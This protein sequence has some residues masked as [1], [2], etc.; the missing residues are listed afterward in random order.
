[1]EVQDHRLAASRQS[2][3][4]LIV[5]DNPADAFL[6]EELL[7]LCTNLTCKISLVNTLAA[8]RQHL[9]DR[10]LP[11]LILLDLHLPDGV[12][13]SNFEALKA[14]EPSIAVVV[15]TGVED[16]DLA[17][18]LI[19]RGAQDYL[20]KGSFDHET[21]ARTIR[22]AIDRQKILSQLAL[23]RKLEQYLAYNDAL[24]GL[25]N[26]QFFRNH[27]SAC[28]A[29]AGIEHTAFAL[30]FIDLD[31]FKYVNDSLGHGVGDQLL[32]T[33]A[34]RLQRSVRQDDLVARI[35]GDEFTII[36]KNIQLQ[37][38]VKA[39]ACKI[40]QSIAQPVYIK[41]FS[42]NVTG[43]IGVCCFPED[44]ENTEVLLKKADIAMYAA[45][46]SG[47]NKYKQY[48]Q[49]MD[50]RAFEEFEILNSLQ[51][52][53]EEDQFR[54]HYQPLWDFEKKIITSVE[55]LIRWEHPKLGF[56]SPARFIPLIEQT[57]MIV[58]LGEWVLKKACQ[59]NIAMQ[60]AT[61]THICT[62]V[63]LSSRQFRS[64]QLL[65]SVTK[66][67]DGNGLDPELLGIE[68][69]ESSAMQNIDRTIQTLKAFQSLGIQVSIDDFGTGYSSLSYLKRLPADILKIDQ[70]FVSGIPLDGEDSS[71][72]S[73]IIGLAHN[74]N[75]NVV[76]E[77][78]ETKAQYDFL[79][80]SQ[81]DKIQG[82]YIS[83]PLQ[84]EALLTL[85]SATN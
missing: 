45:K 1:M 4:V 74:L 65:N 3:D 9:L 25:A 57:D 75:L 60:E 63:N 84:K 70:S 31:G 59:D 51:T 15:L 71:I 49:T 26:R 14:I 80:S 68:I 24:T 36:L 35:G 22:Y 66:I 73:A 56:L 44:G 78:V 30:F 82:Y 39:I 12:G 77:G 85:L 61:D 79:E 34:D 64:R 48:D 55:A 23:A 33:I 53:L 18:E 47:K 50:Q 19:L 10:R 17:T 76:A 54:L 43:S 16:A 46:D 5:E 81:C 8:A 7:S 29:K 52:A 32:Q 20:V 27:L 67:L 40:L 62:T 11:E 72:T 58:P 41:D 28:I 69:T 13:I 83:R 42:L 6:I 38:D 2:L 21:L 37:E